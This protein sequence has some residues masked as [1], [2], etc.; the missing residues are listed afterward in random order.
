LCLCKLYKFDCW[1]HQSVVTIVFIG[2]GTTLIYTD[3]GKSLQSKLD[4][5][6]YSDSIFQE[7]PNHPKS[8]TRTSD[9]CDFNFGVQSPLFWL[10]EVFSS[11]SMPQTCLNSKFLRVISFLGSSLKSLNPVYLECQTGLSGFPRLIKFGHQYMPLPF[12]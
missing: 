5:K 7:K 2:S 9:F 12:S 6:P 8:Q 4:L 11:R 10:L 3:T 1:F